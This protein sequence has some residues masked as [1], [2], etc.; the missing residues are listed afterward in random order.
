M[1]FLPA[2]TVPRALTSTDAPGH[3][4]IVAVITLQPLVVV[5][6]PHGAAVLV[7]L[8]STHL[9]APASI[10]HSAHTRRANQGVCRALTHCWAA[11]SHLGEGGQRARSHNQTRPQRLSDTKRTQKTVFLIK[12]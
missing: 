9:A 11:S 5:T 1:Q 3:G 7:E 2:Y 4:Y 6:R 12:H 8:C 10:W